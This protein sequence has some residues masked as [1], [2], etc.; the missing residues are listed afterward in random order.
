[1]DFSMAF[2]MSVDYI[3]ETIDSSKRYGAMHSS[4]KHRKKDQK[5]ICL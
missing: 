1:M 5:W 2:S 3:H 4:I